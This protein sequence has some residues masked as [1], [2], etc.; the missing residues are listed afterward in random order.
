MLALDKIRLDGHGT[1]ASI[2]NPSA[3][4]ILDDLGGL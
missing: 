4:L 1:F 3:P 2:V